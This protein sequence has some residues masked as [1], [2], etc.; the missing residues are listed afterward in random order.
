[1]LESMRRE[2]SWSAVAVVAAAVAVVV[3]CGYLLATWPP[4]PPSSA[5]VGVSSS[6]SGDASAASAAP[7]A[8]PSESP[9]AAA[10]P[11]MAVLGDSFSADRSSGS[12]RAWPERLGESLGWQVS[13]D[14]VDGSGYLSQGV[15]T[16]F[17]P[18]L[19]AALRPAPD[20][21]VVAGG[22]HDVRTYDVQQVSDA[23][24]RLLD[25]LT[26][27]APDAQVVVVSPFSV[28]PPGPLASELSADLRDVA[29]AH[30]DEYVDASDW[31]PAGE[32][33]VAPDGVHLTGKG[34]KRVAT[35]LEQALK[36]L[37]V[38]KAVGS[39]G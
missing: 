34:E 39:Q 6:G 7:S 32:G 30:D 21:V 28:G 27:K 12:G 11:T 25:R 26:D 38:V 31:L 33:L 15:R 24:N 3:M 37:G 8:T 23:A 20:V 36:R 17:G 9:A 19:R 22:Y 29:D 35:R 13:T 18:R 5:H 1:M 4:A 14:A 2:V 16:S 10:E